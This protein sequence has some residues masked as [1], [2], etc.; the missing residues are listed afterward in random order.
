MLAVGLLALAGASVALLRADSEAR[1]AAA[2]AM[3]VGDR[4]E[5]VVASPCV[6][7]SGVRVARAVD[8][9]WRTFV[10]DDT[11]TIADT[12]RYALPGRGTVA[13]GVE[14]PVRCAP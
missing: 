7:S 5:R 11:R 2:A 6:D 12:A 1:T 9:R 3:L 4:I 10:A 14:V 8:E 13:L